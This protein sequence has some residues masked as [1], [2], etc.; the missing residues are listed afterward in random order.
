MSRRV[1]LTVR[2]GLEPHARSADPRADD[3]S[4]GRTWHNAVASGCKKAL[5]CR[6][7]ISDA[8]IPTDAT[9]RSMRHR[10]CDD[11]SAK[12]PKLRIVQA[13]AEA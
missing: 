11:G 9:S 1:R 2:L 10:D 3:A 6:R 13:Q 12:A 4:N 5:R 8:A 7:E